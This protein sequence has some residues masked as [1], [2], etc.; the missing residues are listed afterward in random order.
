MTVLANVVIPAIAEHIVIMFALLIP[1]TMIEA[2]VIMR[3]HLLRYPE[4][5]KLS[6]IA[7]LF[8]TIV[9]L[10][11]GYVFAALGIIPA[12]LFTELLPKN[13]GSPIGVILGNAIAHGGTIPN[14]FDDIGYSLGTL[15]VMIPYFFVT[16]IVERRVIAKRK[17]ELNTPALTKTVWIMN[18]I[19]YGLIAIPVAIGAINAFVKL[20]AR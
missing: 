4:S 8:S 16:V 3:R 20:Y 7:N 2:V 5:V 9:G 12:G 13:I 18:G 17:P 10:P 15:L 14:K 1:V 11:I 19:T 6:F